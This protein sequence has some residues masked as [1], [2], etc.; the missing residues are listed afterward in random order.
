[1][2]KELAIIVLN[3]NDYQTVY[4]FISHIQSF[5]NSFQ[6]IIVD[7]CSTDNSYEEL[8]KLKNENIFVIQTDKN[9]GY[10]YGNNFGVR[11]AIENNPNL[12]Y[13]GI[14]NPDIILNRECIEKILTSF[15]FSHCSAL[16]GVMY[17]PD[18]TP[19]KRPYLTLPTYSEILQGS[20]YFSKKILK[21]K[22]DR[23]VDNTVDLQIVPALPGCF[24]IIKKKDF[25][26]IGGFDK[27][28]FLYFEENILAK[29]LEQN[30]MLCGIVTGAKYIHHHSKSIGKTYNTPQKVKIYYDSVKYYFRKYENISIIKYYFLSIVLKLSLIEYYIIIQIKKII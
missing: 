26:K 10:A 2:E 21:R 11:F 28:T 12:K 22:R 8:I 17:N 14:S 19:D 3:Y 13:V 4:E 15:E 6:I 16:T 5:V 25:E 24:F 29:R 20:L 30:H 18:G 23:C 27:N 9:K 1:M 7:N